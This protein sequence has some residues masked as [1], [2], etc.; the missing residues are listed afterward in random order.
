MRFVH[1]SDTHLGWRQYGKTERFIDWGKATKCVFEYAV[2]NNVDFVIHSG[3]FFNSY[4]LDQD[5]FLQS[6]ELLQILKDKNIPF[7]VIDGNHDFQRSPQ[8]NSTLDIL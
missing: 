5:A 7:F 1:L 3:D 2:K 6:I 8:R 4:R